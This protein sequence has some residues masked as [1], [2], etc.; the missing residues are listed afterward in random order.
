MQTKQKETILF[1]SMVSFS[2]EKQ[3]PQVE[4]YFLFFLI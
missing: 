4:I 2:A 3:I 1:D